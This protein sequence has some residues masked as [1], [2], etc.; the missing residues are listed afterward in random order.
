MELQLAVNVLMVAHYFRI[1]VSPANYK[2]RFRPLPSMKPSKKLNGHISEQ[3]RE[4][5]A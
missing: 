1:E 5:H 4:I 2:L 3:R